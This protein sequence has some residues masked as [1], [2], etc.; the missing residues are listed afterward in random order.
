MRLY[1]ADQYSA[2]EPLLRHADRLLDEGAHLFVGVDA[3]P[4]EP[5]YEVIY[6]LVAVGVPARLRI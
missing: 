6:S 3:L 5:R 2:R 1:D 4:Q